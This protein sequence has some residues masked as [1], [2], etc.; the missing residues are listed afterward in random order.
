MVTLKE[1]CEAEGYRDVRT[2]IASGNVVF[3]AKASSAKVQAALQKRLHT[4]AGK[5]VGVHVRTLSELEA[6][7][8]G[9]PF[10]GA[11]PN[12]TVTIFLNEAPDTS[13]LSTARGQTEEELRL[14]AREIY[15]YYGDGMAH[16]KLVIP[17]AAD[18]TARNMNT[19]AKLVSIARSATP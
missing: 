10:P 14:G 1:M 3:K 9:N 8:A 15:V 11:Q 12:R 6:V 19:I 7:L 13:V 5:P 2:Y 16:S 4:Y 17:A 18:G